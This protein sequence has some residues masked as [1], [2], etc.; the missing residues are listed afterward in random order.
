MI[1]WRWTSREAA[2]H[3]KKNLPIPVLSSFTAMH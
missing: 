1:T 2:A 3:G